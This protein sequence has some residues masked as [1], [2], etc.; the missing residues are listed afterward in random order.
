VAVIRRGRY[1]VTFFNWQVQATRCKTM[2]PTQQALQA[3][4]RGEIADP[5][6]STIEEHL[7]VCAECQSTL[8]RTPCDDRLMELFRSAAGS[9]APGGQPGELYAEGDDSAAGQHPERD[10]YPRDHHAERDD[11]AAEPR[12]ARGPVGRRSIP[13]GYDL[14]EPLGRGGMGVVFKARQRALGRV[15]AL[16]QIAAGLDADL[17]ELARFRIEAEAAARLK[18]PNIVAV[19]DVGEQDAVPFLAMELVE[20]GSLADRLKAGTIEPRQGA[21]LVATLARAVQHAHDLGV[22]HRDL[23]PANI[24]LAADG[25]PKIADFGLAKRLDA[26]AAQTGSG[27][28]LGT[29]QYMAPEQAGG[30]DAGPSADIYALGAV[31]YEC[32]TGRPPFQ[33][34][35]PLEALEQV[36]F[37]D[38]PLPSRLR[39]RLP[40]DLETV[41]LKCLEKEP[42]RRYASSAALADD[43]DRFL[44]G[45]PIEARPIGRG[46]RIA[47]WIK[48]RPYQAALAVLGAAAMV[49]AFIGLIVHNSRLA[50]EIQ[51]ANESA[52]IAR[53]QK[54]LADGNYRE[55]RAAIGEML[56]EIDSP[57]F[58]DLPRRT[59]L[60]RALREKA[61]LFYEKVIAAADS[62]DPVVRI[63]T[64]HAVHEAANLMIPLGRNQAAEDHLL[65]ALRLY[66]TLSA[67]QPENL[68]FVA[69][70]HSIFVKLG[71]MLATQDTDRALRALEA[72]HPLAERIAAERPGSVAA[73]GD[74]AWCEHNIGSALLRDEKRPNRAADAAPH[75]QRAAELYWELYREAPDDHER[76]VH[77][78]G[79]LANLA[80]V[81]WMAGHWNEAEKSFAE[82]CDLLQG[83]LGKT[84]SPAPREGQ[85]VLAQL[86]LSRGNLAIEQNQ[87]QSALAHT[88]RGIAM[89][90]V[91]LRAEP[92]N[93][94]WREAGFMLHGTR[95][96]ILGGPIARYT[97]AAT[98]WDRALSLKDGTLV[99]RPYRTERAACLIRANDYERGLAAAE[100]L[101]RELA[102]I[103]KPSGHDVYHLACLFGLAAT[104]AKADQRLQSAERERRQIAHVQ[105]ALAWLKRADLAGWFQ[106]HSHRTQAREDPALALVR[107][108]DEFK[109][110][111]DAAEHAV[112]PRK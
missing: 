43:L 23:K 112:Q 94:P 66:D 32:L 12:P 85:F 105:A 22:V 58:A 108:N 107:D 46:E 51:R 97:E 31:L 50:V 39:P 9:V 82:A 15:V 71:V 89:I 20:G 80:T 36:R 102:A 87:P 99:P 106:D 68:D 47:K 73:R 79:T 76:I 28:L 27:A 37:L 26:S 35:T 30:R 16:K 110:L 34:A 21:E 100:E 61:L 41:C 90:D 75:L 63:D 55:A 88:E 1:D 5:E 93:R 6:A 95:A 33:A 54:A 44:R 92:A 78:A 91:L 111:L 4:G 29:P 7:A 67:E 56:N 104:A 18:H 96:E 10:D 45:E 83:S 77:L 101:A 59:E 69:S 53:K 74:L 2:H 52:E 109:R 19:F 17:G 57:A 60:T 3:F 40:R 42:R 24:L 64:A 11:Y 25:T 13:T 14:I 38:P 98:E 49:G 65:R 81:D 62:S 48:R 86:L 103:D 72:A 70:R 84:A 8:E